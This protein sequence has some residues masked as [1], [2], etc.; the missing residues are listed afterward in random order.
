MRGD[1]G[2]IYA[3]YDA[4]S[5]GE[6]GTYYVWSRDEISAAVGEEADTIEDVLEQL[7]GTFAFY[8]SLIERAAE[9]GKTRL[10]VRIVG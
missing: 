8:T 10:G 2:G 7:E 9:H 6:E 5:G 3:S 1:E 4:D